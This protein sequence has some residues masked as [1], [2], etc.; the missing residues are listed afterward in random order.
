MPLDF[1]GQNLKGRSF[2]GRK[3]LTGANFSYADIRGADFTGAILIGANFSHAKAGIQYRWIISLVTAS[4][5]LAAL[6]GFVS[7]K[8]G[9]F[10]S[11]AL[12]TEFIQKYTVVPAVIIVLIIVIFFLV[13]IRYGLTVALANLAWTLIISLDFGLDGC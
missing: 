13:T 9:I 4:L 11:S 7:G 5:F 3:D 1:S 6:T 8:S 12:S 10:A 2:K